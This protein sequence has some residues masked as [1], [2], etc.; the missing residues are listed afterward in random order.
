MEDVNVQKLQKALLDIAAV[1]D[2]HIAKPREHRNI[3]QSLKLIADTLSK[4]L[5]EQ[6]KKED[7]VV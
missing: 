1:C 7:P 6:T 5:S 3:E 4:L 2:E